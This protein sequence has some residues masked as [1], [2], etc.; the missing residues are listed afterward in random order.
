MHDLRLYGDFRGGPRARPGSCQ[1]RPTS[2]GCRR[3]VPAVTGLH[4]DGVVLD[5]SAFFP[6]GGGQPADTGTIEHQGA[7]LMV[8][9]T[10]RRD[11]EL[12][13]LVEGGQPGLEVLRCPAV[14]DGFRPGPATAGTGR[15]G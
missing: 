12:V 15:P 14:S 6:G 11:G 7:E 4:P 13:L 2:A 8:T 9:G 1:D 3:K 10:A 5:R